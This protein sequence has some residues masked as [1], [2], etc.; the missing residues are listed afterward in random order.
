MTD[1]LNDRSIS[2]NLRKGSHTLLPVARTTTCGIETVRFIGNKL[3]QIL[4]S[5]LK[6]TTDVE[7]SKIDIRSWRNFY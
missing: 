1:V 3:W 6:S 4:P 5:S 7:S 2:Y